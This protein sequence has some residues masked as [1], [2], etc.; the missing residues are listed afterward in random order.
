MFVVSRKIYVSNTCSNFI[1]ET[2]K[3]RCQALVLYLSGILISLRRSV[4]INSILFIYYNS[5][6]LRCYFDSEAATVG[7]TSDDS[8]RRPESNE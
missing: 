8:C 1:Q 4:K 7:S 2:L 3:A 5:C 6:F